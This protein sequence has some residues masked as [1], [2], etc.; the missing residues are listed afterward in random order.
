MDDDPE[1]EATDLSQEL[2]LA[3]RRPFLQRIRSRLVDERKISGQC[4][5][6]VDGCGG[7]ASEPSMALVGDDEEGFA[8]DEL[9]SGRRPPRNKVLIVH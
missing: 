4:I 2:N 9:R 5:V 3:H 1:G 7:E 6:T 8:S